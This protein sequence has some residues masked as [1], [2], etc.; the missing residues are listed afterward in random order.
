M[1]IF[2]LEIYFSWT[3]AYF[4]RNK[5][6]HLLALLIIMLLR[7]LNIHNKSYGRKKIG[8]LFI[9]SIVFCSHTTEWMLLTYIYTRHLLM[10]Y[11]CQGK[12]V[13]IVRASFE[14]LCKYKTVI[15]N[16]YRTFYLH[17]YFARLISVTVF[18][19]FCYLRR[20]RHDRAICVNATHHANSLGFQLLIENLIQ[21]DNWLN[22]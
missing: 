17:S 5:T 18:L 12:F 19:F 9:R 16:N 10:N 2:N 15:I 21:L 6:L 22:S 7:C 1:S 20:L 4:A 8:Q 11:L 14:F 13:P 3:N